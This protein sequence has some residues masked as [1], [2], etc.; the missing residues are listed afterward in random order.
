[1]PERRVREK[2]D[3]YLRHCAETFELIRERAGMPGNSHMTFQSRF[4][5]ERWLGPDTRGFCLEQ[6]GRGRR[7]AV[8]C[9]SFVADCL[10]TLDEIGNE[11]GPEVRE[12]GG[13]LLLVP[14]LNAD[15]GWCGDFAEL[16]AAR[17]RGG[18]PD[19]ESLCHPPPPAAEAGGGGP[20]GAAPPPTHPALRM[21]FLT[22]FLDLVGFSIIFPLFPSILRHYLEADGGGLLLGGFL[23]LAGR[24]GG[25]GEVSTMALFGGLLGALYSLL[26][27]VSAPFWG[28]LSDRH[29][30]RPVLLLCLSG[31]TLGHALWALS[32]SFTLLVLARAVGGFMGGN[33][34]VATAVVGD[35]TTRENRSRGMAVV[36]VAFALGFI[37]GP[38]L[39]GLLAQADLA[40]R[41]PGARP[42]GVNPFSAPALLAFALAAW[43]LVWVWRAFPETLPPSRRGG[44]GAGGA[45]TP[46]RSFGRCPIPGSTWSTSA[47]FC[48]SRS[49]PAWSSPSR[50]WPSSAWV[51]AAWTTPGCSSSWGW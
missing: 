7:M 29:G 3:P 8:Y 31:L 34:S 9:P 39:G 32:G 20:P 35:V 42:W 36:G 26:Q 11:L 13:E 37:L 40:A 45:P 15:E 18:G 6:A 49:S 4:G 17:A 22:L 12:R 33:I 23:E 43:N 50:S 5:G 16:A 19:P 10:E 47:I 1:M 51:T 41:F 14:C 38:A 21:V 46:W 24:W 27:F 44:R 48:S 30:R 25:P 28:G 2:G